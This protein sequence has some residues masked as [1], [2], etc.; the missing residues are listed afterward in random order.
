MATTASYK[1][2]RLRQ[3]VEKGRKRSDDRVALPQP[4]TV[5]PGHQDGYCLQAQPPILRVGCGGTPS[6]IEGPRPIPLA[7]RTPVDKWRL[8]SKFTHGS[9][10]TPTRPPSHLWYFQR[11]DLIVTHLIT[12]F[13]KTTAFD[14]KPEFS[15]NECDSPRTRVVG[16]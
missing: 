4:Q 11:L 6:V 15:C 12:M 1:P 14:D 5:Q 8:F 16:D 3:H 7:F 13:P 9:C 10:S 2:L